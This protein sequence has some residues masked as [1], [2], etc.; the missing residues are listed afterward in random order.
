[1]PYDVQGR[2][3]P[4]QRKRECFSSSTTRTRSRSPGAPECRRRRRKAVP[5][6]STSAPG[7]SVSCAPDAPAELR[8]AANCLKGCLPRGGL[9]CFRRRQQ[10]TNKNRAG[11]VWRNA[12]DV[13]T[14]VFGREAR[15]TFSGT[16]DLIRRKCGV[17]RRGQSIDGHR[18]RTVIETLIKGKSR[19]F[20][21]FIEEFFVATKGANRP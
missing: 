12:I 10:T 8:F 18:Y 2:R 15:Q 14:D 19:F 17:S 4:A 6:N 21:I 11:H 1:M 7:R 13:I 3:L 16:Q 20:A 9:C 5:R